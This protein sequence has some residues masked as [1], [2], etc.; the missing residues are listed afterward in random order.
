VR[1]GL[2]FLRRISLNSDLAKSRGGTQPLRFEKLA[3]W[4]FIHILRFTQLFEEGRGEKGRKPS[5]SKGFL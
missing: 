1:A 5:I 2:L 4:V 3:P